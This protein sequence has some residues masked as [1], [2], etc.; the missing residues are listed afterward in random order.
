MILLSTLHDS[1]TIDEHTKKP[2]M[3]M[4]YN[5]TKGGV[6]TVDQMCNA[7]NVARITRRPMAIF[8]SLMN[9]AVINAQIL[10]CSNPENPKP[11]RRDF[12]KNL[13]LSL[14]EPHLTERATIKSLTSDISAFLRSKYQRPTENE[15]TPQQQERRNVEDVAC[16]ADQKMLPLQ[17][18]AIHAKNLLVSNMYK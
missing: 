17:S 11:F 5:I 3:I 8:Y 1:P 15:D 16:V 18:N 9:I 7:Y 13:A 14:M 2:E 10:Y 12:L 6:D 4:D